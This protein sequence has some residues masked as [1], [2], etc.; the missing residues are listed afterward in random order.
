MEDE[1]K[2]ALFVGG[3]ADG[4]TQ[5]IAQIE[6]ELD[7]YSNSYLLRGSLETKTLGTVQV[8][9]LATMRAEEENQRMEII[10]KVL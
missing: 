10:K 2:L 5:K 1:T 4:F 8:Y 6:P 7:W 9:V 3:N